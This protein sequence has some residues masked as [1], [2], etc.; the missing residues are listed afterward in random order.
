MNF[1]LKKSGPFFSQ[2]AR[3][4][5]H[6]LWN[7]NRWRCQKIIY[8]ANDK[9]FLSLAK[10]HQTIRTKVAH[11]YFDVRP[12]SKIY[13]I[14]NHKIS[15]GPRESERDVS[16]FCHAHEMWFVINFRVRAVCVA[17]T[18]Q[19]RQRW[20]RRPVSYA[21]SWTLQ[22]CWRCCDNIQLNPKCKQAKWLWRSSVWICKWNRTNCYPFVG[23]ASCKFDLSKSKPFICSA[24][25]SDC[26]WF[27]LK[28]TRWNCQLTGQ[29]SLITT[30]SICLAFRW[31]NHSVFLSLW[32]FEKNW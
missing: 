30:H 2:L 8:K 17:L 27:A 32:S 9:C 25:S 26:L 22:R 10:T 5:Y 4:Y 3:N 6:P 15:N 16:C 21:V 29:F 24:L 14:Q 13:P 23:I 28:I 11:I 19:Q 1:L 12:A 7:A 31:W 20:R 18:R